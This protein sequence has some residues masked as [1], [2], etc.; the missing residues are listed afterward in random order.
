MDL[1]FRHNRDGLPDSRDAS[2]MK[3]LEYQPGFNTSGPTEQGIWQRWMEA[4]EGIQRK[5]NT[6]QS[7][8]D[9]SPE[10]SKSMVICTSEHEQLS[11]H[12]Y[13]NSSPSGSSTA[14]NTHLV[15]AYTRPSYGKF[16]R[17]S[18]PISIQKGRSPTRLASLA[19]GDPK[20][21]CWTVSFEVG[22]SSTKF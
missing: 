5:A 10:K 18:Q 11:Q 8:Q 12:L 9:L 6:Q 15:G 19:D 21:A 2:I 4:L 13:E 7:R 17:E 16:R 20:R 1:R 22:W 14:L 3:P